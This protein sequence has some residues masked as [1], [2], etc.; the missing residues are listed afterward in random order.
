MDM[1]IAEATGQITLLQRRD[2]LIAQEQHLMLQQR[3]VKLLELAI[4][5]RARQLNVFHQSTDIR[6]QRGDT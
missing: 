4:A 6:P 1:Q 5:Q 3:M 2:W